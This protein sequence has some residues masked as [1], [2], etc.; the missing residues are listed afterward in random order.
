VLG[1]DRI[2]VVFDELPAITDA[3]RGGDAGRRPVPASYLQWKPLPYDMPVTG[4][5][6]ACVGAAGEGCLFVDL[7]AAPG[8]VAIE[9]DQAAAVRLAESI[10][11]Q[12]CIG[13]A[14]GRRCAVGAV[15]TALPPPLPA[16]AAWFSTPGELRAPGDLAVG[17][18]VVFCE[19][20]SHDDASALNRYV[21]G[22][23]HRVIPVIV[24]GRGSAPWHLIARPGR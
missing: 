13:S 18:E 15:G 24:A 14:A 21:A 7:A 23:A 8:A 5:A 16:R 19:V 10:A 9:G 1:E 2:E 11:H 17:T 20:Q 6:F 12:L 22:S 4:A 3:G